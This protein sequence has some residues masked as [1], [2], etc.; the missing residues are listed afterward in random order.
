MIV[1]G[2]MEVAAS[3]RMDEGSESAEECV[4]RSLSRRAKMGMIDGIL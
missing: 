1:N 3:H 4:E 2:T